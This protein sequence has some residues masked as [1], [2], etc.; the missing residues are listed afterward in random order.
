M[1]KKGRYDEK[2]DWD[3]MTQG[4]ASHHIGKKMTEKVQKSKKDFKRKPKHKNGN[5][6]DDFGYYPD[7][8]I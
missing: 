4:E 2:V 3:D 8:D 6:F 1:K 5:N 7:G